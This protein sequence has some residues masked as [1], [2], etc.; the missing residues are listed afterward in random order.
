MFKSVKPLDL[1][2]R[3]VI[4]G[5]LFGLGLLFGLFFIFFF[6]NQ[7]NALFNPAEFNFSVYQYLLSGASQFPL[8]IIFFPP[9]FPW[10]LLFNIAFRL[11]FSPHFPP[12]VLLILY[13]VSVLSSPSPFT[14]FCN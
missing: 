9:V 2:L 11:F 14:S 7:F 4:I 3:D 13:N 10:V 1:F 8:L 6:P 5:F 12:S